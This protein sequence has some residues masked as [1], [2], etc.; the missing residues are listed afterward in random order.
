MRNIVKADIY[1]RKGLSGAQ[2]NFLEGNFLKSVFVSKS[3]DRVK[4][5]NSCQ[6]TPGVI[7]GRDSFAE[8]LR[9]YGRFFKAYIKSVYRRVICDSHFISSFLSKV[10]NINGYYNN[11]IQFFRENRS[12]L[13]NFVRF[14]IPRFIECKIFSAFQPIQFR[15]GPLRCSDSFNNFFFTGSAEDELS[16]GVLAES[17]RFFHWYKDSIFFGGSQLS[18]AARG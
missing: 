2:A 13:L 7:I 11:L 9:S 3:L 8:V 6:L 17:D 12:Y 10:I 4:Y 14:I 16:D 5:F 18:Q 15:G 1:N